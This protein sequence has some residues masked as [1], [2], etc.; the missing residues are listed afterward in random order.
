MRSIALFASAREAIPRLI[1][2]VTMPV[3]KGLVS[4]SQS[5]GRAAAFVIMRRGE[6]SPVTASP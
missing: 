2:V 6:T 5:P 1:P 4:T 3:P